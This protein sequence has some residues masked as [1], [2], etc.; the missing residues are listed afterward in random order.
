MN[1]F[2]WL[3]CV[4]FGSLIGSVIGWVICYVLKII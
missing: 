4:I 2:V 3:L 1:I